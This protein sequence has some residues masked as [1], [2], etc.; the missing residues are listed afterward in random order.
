MKQ[1]L[2]MILSVNKDDDDDDADDADMSRTS[3]KSS[4]IYNSLR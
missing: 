4:S 1:M 2:H 3:I